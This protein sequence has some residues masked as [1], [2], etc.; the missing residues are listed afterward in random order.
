VMFPFLVESN[1]TLNWGDLERHRHS[2]TLPKNPKISKH[3]F[4]GF[5]VCVLSCVCEI[6]EKEAF[7]ATIF[8]F[9]TFYLML[10]EI[11]LFSTLQ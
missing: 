2:Q 4:V 6:K 11:L 5:L 1:I 3:I 8:R 10:S 9:P 7:F